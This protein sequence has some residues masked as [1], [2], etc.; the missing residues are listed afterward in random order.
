MSTS[1][2]GKK[3]IALLGAGI[4]S[5][6]TALSLATT[7]QNYTIT[8]IASH[9]PGDLSLDYTS[10]RAGGVWRTFATSKPEDAALR[11]FDRRTYNA[12][13]E[14]LEHG[15]GTAGIE[16]ESQDERVKRVGLGIRECVNLWGTETEETQGGGKG[17][18]WAGENGVVRDY[19]VLDISDDEKARGVHFGVRYKT[20]S[21]NVPG[22]LSY[23]FERVKALGVRII[24]ADVGISH[25]LDGVVK[26]VGAILEQ[27]G[28]PEP[29]ALINCTGLSA[30]H[31]LSA[32]EK[33]TLFPIRGQT[34]LVRG[35]SP[36]GRTF[37]DFGIDDELVYVIPRPG[38]GTTI[39]G[40]CKQI[41]NWD[42]NLDEVLNER[43]LERIKKGKLAEELRTG[44]NGDFE[45]LTTQVG[46][47]PARKGGPRVEVEDG[48]KEGVW[49]LH[50]YGHS[51][52]GYQN[53]IGCAEQVVELV[54]GL[55]GMEG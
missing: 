27:N 28:L 13:M 32:P 17:F 38:S 44:P 21:I 22:Y 48:K 7:S 25:G 55:P 53:S 24:K 15:D 33:D 52:G 40:G 8:V 14:L 3:H 42:P 36:Q 31:F 49:V 47:R 29:F 43:I 50:S 26:G 18:W 35:E 34:I 19:E 2:D 51:G 5:L 10:P 6:Q 37:T 4:T 41:G 30:R 16:N 20:I 54:N 11:Q 9:I 46:F 39:L 12:W 1:K 45:V 23:V